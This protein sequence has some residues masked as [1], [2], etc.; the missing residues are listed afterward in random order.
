MTT[1]A[2]FGGDTGRKLFPDAAKMSR[3]TR[4]SVGGMEDASESHRAGDV[5]Q[6]TQ[7]SNLAAAGFPGH[8]VH[9]TMPWEICREDFRI[10]FE[11]LHPGLPR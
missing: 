1:V 2:V 11:T 4:I 3:L 6:G 7:Q 9:P 8:R 10:N 5:L